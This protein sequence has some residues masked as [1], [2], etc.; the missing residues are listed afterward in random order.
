MKTSRFTVLFYAFIY[1]LTASSVSYAGAWTMPDGKAYIKVSANAYDSDEH[2]NADG[3]AVDFEANGTFEDRN[4]GLYV[5]YGVNDRLSLVYSGAYKFLKKKDDQV[6][7]EFN[8]LSDMDLALKYRLMNNRAGVVSVQ[9]LVKVP[10]AYDED[11][12]MLPGNAQYD[13]EIRL[14]Y[15]RS[16]YPAVPGYF[17]VEGAYRLRDD[18]PA[19]EMRFLGEFGVDFLKKGFARFKTE[20]IIGMDNEDAMTETSNPNLSADYDL[21]KMSL[22]L[23]CRFTD[24][25]GVEIETIREIAGARVSK[26]NIWSA[27]LTCL[28]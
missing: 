19:D 11:E 20:A 9:G 28:Y 13:Y 18:A 21:V 6:K 2:Y 15:G 27:S 16:L 24:T 12:V 4:V 5:E 17:N 7:Q 3:D 23:G 25:W 10:E 14:M 22:A 26:G 8:G 1:V